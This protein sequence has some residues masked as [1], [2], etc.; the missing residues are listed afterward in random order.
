MDGIFNIVETI[1][2]LCNIVVTNS[3]IQV[4]LAKKSSSA[5]ISF[6]VY[7]QSTREIFS[8]KLDTPNIIEDG[9]CFSVQPVVRISPSSCG[10]LVN[11]KGSFKEI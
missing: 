5:I 11:G 3:N 7:N 4:I 1:M 2:S 8:C 9:R 6:L 10:F